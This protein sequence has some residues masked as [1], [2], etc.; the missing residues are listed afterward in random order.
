[1]SYLWLRS[2]KCKQYFTAR[3]YRG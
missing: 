1:M 2:Q 3:R